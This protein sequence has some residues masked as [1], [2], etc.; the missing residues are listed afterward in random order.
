MSNPWSRKGT[1]PCSHGRRHAH[2]APHRNGEILH[3]QGIMDAETA[4]Y[5]NKTAVSRLSEESASSSM[6]LTG[7]PGWATSSC[8]SSEHRPTSWPTGSIHMGLGFAKGL[9]KARLSHFG[10]PPASRAL[11][12]NLARRHQGGLG[13]TAAVLIIG[14]QLSDDDFV[15]AYDPQKSRSNSCAM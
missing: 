2:P 11:S 4:T 15:G 6:T 10:N 5:T 7:V 8:H 14:N 13:L 12:G 9:G 1:K 3:A